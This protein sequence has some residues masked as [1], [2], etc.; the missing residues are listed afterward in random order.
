MTEH[1]TFPG[2]PYVVTSKAGCTIT[3]ASGEL[4]ETCEPGKQKVVH[5]PSEKLFTSAPAIV[6][7]TFNRAALAL[8]LLG[9]GVKTP[10]WVKALEAA[11]APQMTSAYI[12]EYK[13][14]TLFV[15]SD[16]EQQAGLADV[17][18]AVAAEYAPEGTELV[19]K[20]MPPSNITSAKYKSVWRNRS[21]KLS[22]YAPPPTDASV[23][24]LFMNARIDIIPP[25][26]FAGVTYAEQTFI[27]CQAGA[28]PVKFM[29]PV[30]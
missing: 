9:G 11:L 20:W 27:S 4:E 16:Y 24:G 7:E 23:N 25:W 2:K 10:A 26:V 5:A 3:D 22:E 14:G 12:V 8:R 17:V 18:S 30:L 21:V 15:H 29:F 1:E 19:Q 6:R 13:S 28:L